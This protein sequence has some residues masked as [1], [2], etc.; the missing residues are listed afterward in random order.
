[1]KKYLWMSSAVIMTGTLRVKDKK[2]NGCTQ[3]HT[4]T[5]DSSFQLYPVTIKKA[6]LPLKIWLLYLSL[7]KLCDP[8]SFASIALFTNFL[9]LISVKTQRIDHLDSA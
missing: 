7:T 2:I 9:I 4:Y 5:I 6:L 3:T 8:V 1:M